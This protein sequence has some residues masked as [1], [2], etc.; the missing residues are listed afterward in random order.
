MSTVASVGATSSICWRTLR[1]AGAVADEVARA[2]GG[3]DLG[4]QVSV[5]LLEALLEI[6]D[7]LEGICVGDA[8]RGVIGKDAQPSEIASERSA[9]SKMAS[10]PRMLS[11]KRS[12]SPAKVRMP[13]R[14]NQARSAIQ[15]SV[16]AE[17]GEHERLAAGAADLADLAYA[18]R[19]TA[20]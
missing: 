7:F 15:S 19:K 5:F 17:V 2:L 16:A 13:S 4:A 11:R 6:R 3:A 9:R 20:E 1:K 10:T 18:E 14:S 12:G 8:H